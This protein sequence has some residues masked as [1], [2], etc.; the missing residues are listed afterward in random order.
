MHVFAPALLG[1]AK[2]VLRRHGDDGQIH[3]TR[4][5]LHRGESRQ[6]LD[7]IGGRIDGV[8]RSREGGRPQVAHDGG[9]HGARL[10]GRADH[11]YSTRVQHPPQRTG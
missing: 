7:G 5:G 1:H 3:N 4:D 6:R 9:T 11:R 8:D 10:F 2:N